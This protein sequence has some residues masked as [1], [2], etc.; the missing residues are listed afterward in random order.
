MKAC[1]K[2][3]DSAVT[4]LPVRLQRSW[5]FNSTTT[6][7][8]LRFGLDEGELESIWLGRDDI[9]DSAMMK[10]SQK[11]FDSITTIPLIWPRWSKSFD[12]SM[13]KP[14]W[15]LLDSASNSFQFG[16]GN[17]SYSAIVKPNQKVIHWV[18]IS[19]QFSHDEVKVSIQTMKPSRKVLDM[20]ATMS[21]IRPWRSRVA[22]FSTRL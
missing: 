12:S 9:S 18:V 2:V 11:V 3:F 16:H 7:S 14:S 4:T 19:P 15:K 10:P 1:R 20:A 8:K 13:M 6:K 21:S 22:K 17:L 5:N